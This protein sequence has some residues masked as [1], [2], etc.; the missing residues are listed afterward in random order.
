MATR[1]GAAIRD[2]CRQHDLAPPSI[3]L[4]SP[5]L[6]CV[7]TSIFAAEGLGFTGWALLR[8]YYSSKS[9]LRLRLK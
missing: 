9:L 3:V 5:L 2:M 4:S 7:E 6:R 8:L 1:A